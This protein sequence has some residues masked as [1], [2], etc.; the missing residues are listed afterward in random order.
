MQDAPLT[1]EQ[2]SAYLRQL[3][4]LS[5]L[6]FF[7]AVVGAIIGAV[8]CGTFA[9]FAFAGLECVPLYA[10]F[11]GWQPNF[12]E[13]STRCVDGQAFCQCEMEVQPLADPE[14]ADPQAAE[15]TS[16]F[17]Q[18]GTRW[19]QFEEFIRDVFVLDG[20]QHVART[21]RLS[22]VLT[23]F[24]L[25]GLFYRGLVLNRYATQHQLAQYN[26]FREVRRSNTHVLSAFIVALV[27]VTVAYLLFSLV[28]LFFAEMF[29]NLALNTGSAVVAVMV[30]GAT[31]GFLTTY[32]V[33]MLTT[34][35]LVLFGIVAFAIG[36]SAGF[37]GA[38]Q[39]FTDGATIQW[40]QGAISTLGEDPETD[41]LFMASFICL[42]L[43]LYVLWLDMA[44]FLHDV[45]VD[46]AAR[47]PEVSQR[48]FRLLRL[49]YF[50]AVA[51][52]VSVGSFPFIS[53][54]SD[55]TL[56][57]TFLLHTLAA[58]WTILVFVV[59]GMA[60]LTWYL[61]KRVFSEVVWRLSRFGLALAILSVVLYGLGIINLTVMEFVPMLLV[62][63]WLYAAVDSF[64]YYSNLKALR[65]G[66][67]AQLGSHAPRRPVEALMHWQERLLNWPQEDS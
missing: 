28:W 40:W 67:A 18:L 39:T 48:I 19:E 21:A 29:H 4:R 41:L 32:W 1:N 66:Q 31:V 61:R 12:G 27:A 35:R 36:L 65:E 30:F 63:A 58:A 23:V 6:H 54:G 38:E 47:P 55:L 50:S 14:P 5:Q 11:E 59:G 51:A 56:V 45:I 43:V 46:A 2:Q 62:G 44:D 3:H 25:S 7:W 34:H 64:L 20:K 13:V 49:L 37:V 24:L 52:V 10:G 26:E 9:L 33:L 16:L 22:G 8:I 15:E 57:S 60:T 17:A 53:S 42:A